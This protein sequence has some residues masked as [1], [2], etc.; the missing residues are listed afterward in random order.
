M[1]P[2]SEERI[3]AKGNK[4]LVN[5]LPSTSPNR[6]FLVIILLAVALVT[7]VVLLATLMPIYMT[8]SEDGKSNG[9]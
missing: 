3:N 6:R 2:A 4:Y 9:E 8:G 1:A 7:V 5:V